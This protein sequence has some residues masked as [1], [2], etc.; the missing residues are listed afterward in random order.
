L[1]KLAA[2]L[3]VFMVF[4]AGF[5]AVKYYYGEPVGQTGKEPK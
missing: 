3:F 1:S 5:H 4:F 2:W